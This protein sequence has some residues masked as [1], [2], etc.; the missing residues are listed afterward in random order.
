[1][2]KITPRI[3]TLLFIGLLL[4]KWSAAQTVF[5]PVDTVWY[6]GDGQ[7]FPWRLKPRTGSTDT[8]NSKVFFQE[9]RLNDTTFNFNDPTKRTKYYISYRL[10]GYMEFLPQNYDKP[11]NANK[12][13][14]LILFLPGCGE[15]QHGV[16]YLNPPYVDGLGNLIPITP[17]TTS[18]LGK[19]FG[20]NG[21]FEALPIYLRDNGSYMSNIPVKTPGEVYN[22]A[23]GPREAVISMALMYRGDQGLCNNVLSPT[24][25]DIDS[26]I[27]LAIKLYRVDPQ[28][29]YLTGLSNGGNLG[30]VFPSSQTRN[31]L[32]ATVPVCAYNVN[33]TTNQHVQQIIDNQT[34]IFSVTNAYDYNTN[35]TGVDVITRVNQATALMNAH[36]GGSNWL[37]VNN[38]HYSNQTP[39]LS[40]DEV[41]AQGLRTHDAWTRA[42]PTR[43]GYAFSSPQPPVYLDPATGDAYT[44]YEWMLLH[45]NTSVALILPVHVTSFKAERVNEG[46]ELNWVTSTESNSLE[47]ILERSE[48]GSFYSKLT[49][50]PAAG[51]SSSE[52]RYNYLDTKE[53]QSRFLYYRLLQKDRDG[54][55]E[56][57]GIRKV[58]IGTKNI[59]ARLFP[60]VTPST[61]T[62]EVSNN[63]REPLDLR[64]IDMSGRT[65]LR[66]VIPARQPR[67]ILDVS[68]FQK[69]V[70][71]VEA[72]NQ[73]NQITLKLIKN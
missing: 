31:K 57:I 50:L 60:N 8:N 38:F 54:R 56:V 68:R 55:L 12:L 36:P 3:I 7:P 17:N 23:T 2:Q 5:D 42:Y 41:I 47:F 32:A 37:T 70:Y 4:S 9:D 65:L 51:N 73:D 19:L 29:I 24:I 27:D 71:I 21:A 39:G 53:T 22:P 6:N 25:T 16:F 33:I 43:Y 35:N 40:R 66:Q 62:F 61:T 18:G 10:P 14:P 26:A 15:I 49:T 34:R 63:L 45:R 48:D 28:R 64:I 58:F 44:A 13:Y 11:E 30:W 46:V 69:G 59:T 67:T 20:G 52:R 1:M 72:R